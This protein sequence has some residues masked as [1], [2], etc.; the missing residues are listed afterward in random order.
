[1]KIQGEKFVREAQ[2]ERGAVDPEAR[3]AVLAFS[4]DTP[5]ER[6]YYREILDH[7]PKAVRLDRLRAG[8]AVLM[9]HDWRDQV[10]VVESVE[11]GADRKGRAV[12]RFGKGARAS[13]IFQDVQDGIRR[14]VSFGYWI[15]EHTERKASDGALE[16]TA[17]DWEPYEVSMVAVPADVRVGVGRSANVPDTTPSQEKTTMTT[18]TPAPEAPTTQNR[19]APVDV[20]AIE[21]EA[22]TRELKR[23]TDLENMGQQFAKFGGPE[24][25]RA[26]IAEG[27]TVGDL[28]AQIL[29][30]VKAQKPPSAD[31]GLTDKE[32]ESFSFL[33]ALHAL[34]NPGDRKAQEAA[35]FERVC[36]EAAG[37]RLGKSP[38]GIL[39]PTDVQRAAV[40]GLQRD[41]L[42]GT[43]TAGGN[44]VS[45]DL[46]AANFIDVLRNRLAVA[47]MGA[48]YLPGLVGNIAIPR[49][50]GAST[51][52]WV[53]ENG[54]PTESQQAFD[55]VTM[56]PKTV[57]AYTD[58]AR[59][60]L[61]Q[62]SI[63]VEAFVRNDLA[64]VLA[65]AIDLAAINGSGASNQ[66]RG[67]LQTAG[68]GSVAGGTNG[69]APTWDHMIDLETQVAT[70]N[71]DMGTLGY[72]TNAKARG[73]LKRTQKFASTNGDPIW[74]RD[75]TMNGYRAMASNQVPSN[76]V[77]G[78]SGAVCSAIAF[79]N[80]ADLL[81]G[82]WGGLDLT[83]DP[84]TGS[85]AGTVRVVALQDVDVAVR[86][87]E[88]F[89][90]ML[91]ALTV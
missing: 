61:L 59:K 21:R 41:L 23:I 88:S 15:H 47:V 57:G 66:P 67:V 60:L 37:R 35:A 85:T 42:V 76:L 56:S 70:A 82:L 43:P 7:S 84:Y 13:E 26:A 73:K 83:V 34:A 14:N 10:G 54:A 91:D 81:I 31:I 11:I 62:S 3:T 80:W 63:A 49:Q 32:A 25:A 77:K 86:R 45:T 65:L 75:S 64:Q 51:A 16:I 58:I 89:S 52:Y 18:E 79:G 55:Q 27:K 5:I 2:F 38:Q 20:A 68:I 74:E 40:K 87:A 24:L 53:A 33:R 12:V 30:R 48:T 29:E 72:L 36:S 17:T 4:S 69:L 19:A 9:D 50:T 46:L 1:M 6:G 8:G 78:S 71:A 90:A 39:V 44:T 22:R 28:Q